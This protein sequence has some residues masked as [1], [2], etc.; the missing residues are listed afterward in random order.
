MEYVTEWRDCL[1]MIDVGD[2]LS[3]SV[4]NVEKKSAEGF[5]IVGCGGHLV[6]PFRHVLPHHIS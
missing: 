4:P 3:Q 1:D 2:K 5:V 6:L